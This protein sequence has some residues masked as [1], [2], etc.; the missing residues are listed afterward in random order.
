MSW[1]Q[2]FEPPHFILL[3]KKS[4]YYFFQTHPGQKLSK[5]HENEL[6]NLPPNAPW[7]RK[8]MVKNRRLIGVLIPFTFYNIVW[9]SLAI[10]HDYFAYF[11]E[12]S[13]ATL[14]LRVAQHW[15]LIP[16]TILEIL[17]KI[18]VHQQNLELP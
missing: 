13:Q 4:Y 7:H 6:Q 12:R 9:W 2:T 5:S 8:L 14:F 17:A 11:P 10:K 15:M 18:R 16:V 3:N 1:R